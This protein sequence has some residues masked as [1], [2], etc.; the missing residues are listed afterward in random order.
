M[1]ALRDAARDL[2]VHALVFKRLARDQAG[3]EAA[4]LLARVGVADADRAEAALQPIEMLFESEGHLGIHRHHFVDAVAEDE[5]AVEHRHL[6][7]G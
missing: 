6:G 4:P 5:A 3:D 2:E 1:V 7:F